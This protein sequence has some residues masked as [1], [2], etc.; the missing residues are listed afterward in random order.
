MDERDWCSI[1]RTRCS[2][3][4]SG[5]ALGARGQTASEAARLC[6]CA[7]CSLRTSSPLRLASLLASASLCVD[8]HVIIGPASGV[9]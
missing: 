5:C 6:C 8:V 7:F 1:C 9:I 2:W 3:A 4:A